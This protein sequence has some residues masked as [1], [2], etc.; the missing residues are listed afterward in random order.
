MSA[1]STQFTRCA[2]QLPCEARQGHGADSA[3]A[4]SRRRTQESRPHR[5][6]SGPRRPHSGRSCPPKPARRVVAGRHLLSGYRRAA[7]VV[8]GSAR[9]GSAACRSCR[10]AS[11]S[12][13]YI[14]TVIPIDSRTRLPLLSPKRAFERYGI[15]MMQQCGEPGLVGPMG[16]RVHPREIRRQGSPALCPAPRFLA[17]VLSRLVPSLHASRFLR[18]LHQ[19][20]EPVRLPTSAR[21]TASVF[22]RRPPPP[23]TN[24]AAP[25]GPLMVPMIAFHA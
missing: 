1:S 23:E 20:Y 19:Y 15:D 10:L 17:W 16:R 8:A 3:S 9:C 12:I 22:P 13:S 25:V 5:W 11:K 7:P 24:P 21:T 2:H 6:H 18:R 4:G 14:S